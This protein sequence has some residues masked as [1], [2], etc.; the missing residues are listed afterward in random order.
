MIA[1]EHRETHSEQVPFPR[2]LAHSRLEDCVID[3]CAETEI[4]AKIKKVQVKRF[5]PC[6][7]AQS[8]KGC[9]NQLSLN[10]N[11]GKNGIGRS[12]K[13]RSLHARI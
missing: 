5:L 2:I 6:M 10:V 4:L 12:W 11:G 1:L 3:T 7:M 13:R 9:R 8:G